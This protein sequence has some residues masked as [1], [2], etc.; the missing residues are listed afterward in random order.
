MMT[1]WYTLETRTV[2]TAID[3]EMGL[4]FLA[5][6]DYI[7]KNRNIKDPGDSKFKLF[8]NLSKRE[9]GLLISRRALLPFGHISLC[10]EFNESIANEEHLEASPCELFIKQ[11]NEDSRRPLMVTSPPLQDAYPFWRFLLVE[12][13]YRVGG[14]ACPPRRPDRLLGRVA[15]PLVKG[16]RGVGAIRRPEVPCSPPGETCWALY[17]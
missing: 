15:C 10:N 9:I 1:R 8:S 12:P 11:M 6:F 16:S 4:H 13:C 7:T 5:L 14:A 3:T 2:V 17:L